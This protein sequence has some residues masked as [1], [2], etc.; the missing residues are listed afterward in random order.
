MRPYTW[1][2]SGCGSTEGRESPAFCATCSA[3]RPRSLPDGRYLAALRRFRDL[4]ASGVP[5]RGFD[6]TTP[7]DKDTQ[8]NWGLCSS[9]PALWPDAEDHIWPYSFTS[10]GRSAPI[11]R[12]EDHPCPFDR[13]RDQDVAPDA[14]RNGCF[15]RCEFFHAS[16]KN[17]RPDREAVLARYDQLIARA[18]A[19]A[20]R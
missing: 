9:D 1:R 10:E 7:G 11:H 16:K 3:D 4:V 6:D 13:D 12:R 18:E 19:K 8:V 15:Y 20:A 14:F 17:P 2:C 5:L